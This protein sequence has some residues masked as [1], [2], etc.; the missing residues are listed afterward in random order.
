MAQKVATPLIQVD[1]AV[2]TRFI[3][4][5]DGAVRELLL[6]ELED[7]LIQGCMSVYGNNQTRIAEAL[8]INRGT[9]RTRMKEFGYIGP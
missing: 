1:P 7:L 3:Q 4:E 6:R 9:L 8:G 2:F 5:N